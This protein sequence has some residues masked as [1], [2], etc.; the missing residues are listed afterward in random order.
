[1]AFWHFGSSVASTKLFLVS[2]SCDFFNLNLT[3]FIL[4][5]SLIQIKTILKYK[6]K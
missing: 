6:R 5:N 4:I 1:L 2:V 3:H